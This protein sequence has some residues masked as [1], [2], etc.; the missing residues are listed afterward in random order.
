MKL[1]EVTRRRD[2][3]VFASE[4]VRAERMDS[5]ILLAAKKSWL[6]YFYDRKRA[7]VVHEGKRC[8]SEMMR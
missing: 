6:R 3:S 4:V 8:S 2:K 1:R 5:P 7:K